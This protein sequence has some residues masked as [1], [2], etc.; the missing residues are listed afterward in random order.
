MTKAIKQICVKD[1][2]RFANYNYFKIPKLNIA[3]KIIVSSSSK[4]ALKVMM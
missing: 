2:K 1:Q 4:I 3:M